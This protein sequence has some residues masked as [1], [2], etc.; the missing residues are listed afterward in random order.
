MST[1][2]ITL[3]GVWNQL[4][5]LVFPV[6]ALFLLKV[7][8]GETALLGTA[9]FIGVVVLGVVV[10]FLVLVLY[11]DEPRARR[12]RRRGA[13]R[14]VGEGQGPAQAR[15]VGRG[16]LRALSQRGRRSARAAL[17]RAHARDVRRAA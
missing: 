13:V 8:G 10:A 1:R 4:A 12:R 11:S 7:D 15:G 14:L 3:T 2:A 17:A 16:E 5:N 9:A 6:V